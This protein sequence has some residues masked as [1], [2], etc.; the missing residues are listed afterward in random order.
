MADVT[1]IRIHNFSERLLDTVV[2]FHIMRMTDSLF[3]WMGKEAEL[4]SLSVAM[5]TKYVSQYSPP[6]VHMAK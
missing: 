4:S 3:I 5:L 2:H 1:D 6:G